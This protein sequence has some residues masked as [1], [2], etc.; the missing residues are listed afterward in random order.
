MAKLKVRV[1]NRIYN[2]ARRIYN[3]ENSFFNGNYRCEVIGN[4][5]KRGIC[6]KHVW[7]VLCADRECDGVGIGCAGF[8]SFLFHIQVLIFC[9]NG[10]LESFGACLF[11]E[12]PVC[13]CV[14]THINSPPPT[15]PR[16]S[17]LPFLHLSVQ[18]FSIST[19]KKFQPASLFLVIKRKGSKCTVWYI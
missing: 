2:A 17:L 15:S 7:C 9:I 19:G 6:G 4:D 12:G 11:L 5:A 13:V 16:S 8:S 14:P 1:R 10:S 3:C 18:I